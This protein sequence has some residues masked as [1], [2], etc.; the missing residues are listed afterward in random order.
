MIGL[1]V[2]TSG[3]L[4]HFVD[5]KL[6]GY[7]WYTDEYHPDRECNETSREFGQTLALMSDVDGAITCD[8]NNAPACIRGCTLCDDYEVLFPRCDE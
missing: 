1:N 7:S 8:D 4:Y 5:G 6:V 3:E 2:G